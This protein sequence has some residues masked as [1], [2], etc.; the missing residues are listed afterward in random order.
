ML[1]SARSAVSDLFIFAV[2]TLITSTL[3]DGSYQARFARL[4]VVAA[5]TGFPLAH[6]RS[7][8]NL[9]AHAADRI[10]SARQAYSETVFPRN[11]ELCAYTDPA[12]AW[13]VLQ[14]VPKSGSLT[15]T[16]PDM[17]GVFLVVAYGVVLAFLTTSCGYVWDPDTRPAWARKGEKA[18]GEDAPVGEASRKDPGSQAGD[19]GS[20]GKGNGNGNGHG[21]GVKKGTGAGSVRADARI[22]PEPD[23]RRAPDDDDGY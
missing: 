4:Y 19:D 1:P 15:L 8:D 2:N 22:H 3:V 11:Q 7:P 13:N 10:S 14:S 21:N 17:A 20:Y 12:G 5:L 23:D 9:D 6:R 16:V 18:A